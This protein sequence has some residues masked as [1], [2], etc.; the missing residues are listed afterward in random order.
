MQP[1]WATKKGPSMRANSRP[2]GPLTHQII[3]LT[4]HGAIDAVESLAAQSSPYEQQT[5][6][7][8]HPSVHIQGVPAS[9]TLLSNVG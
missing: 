9:G 7:W 2:R 5:R 1:Q 4:V 8:S 3:F 6:D